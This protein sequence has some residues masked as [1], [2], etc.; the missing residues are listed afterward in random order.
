[1]QN[2]NNNPNTTTNN[3]QTN[4]FRLGGDDGNIFTSK[5]KEAYNQFMQGTGMFAGT[6]PYM[7]PEVDPNISFKEFRQSEFNPYGPSFLDKTRSY[8]GGE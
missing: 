2:Q 4:Q 3:N 6:D 5:R 7:N 8:F 1:M